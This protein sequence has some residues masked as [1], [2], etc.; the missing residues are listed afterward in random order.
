MKCVHCE[1][2]DATTKLKSLDVC[3][4]CCKLIPLLRLYENA[5]ADKNRKLE[6][7]YDEKIGEICKE[8]KTPCVLYEIKENDSH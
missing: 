6:K 2:R 8:Y 7:L 4:A 3:E 5:R 1:K